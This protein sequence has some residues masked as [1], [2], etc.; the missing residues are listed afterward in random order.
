M[1]CL[2]FDISVRL[3]LYPSSSYGPEAG[4]FPPY[5]SGICKCSIPF[6][7]QLNIFNV[8]FSVWV[9][10]RVFVRVDVTY[11]LPPGFPLKTMH[12]P[13]TTCSYFP[14]DS[15]NKNHY[16]LAV[17]WLINL[18]SRIKHIFCGSFRLYIVVLPSPTYLFTAGAEGFYFHL[19]TF[20]HTPQS[21]GPLWTRDRLGAETSTWQHKHC[22]RNKH[23]CPRWDSNSRSQ[24]ALGRRPTP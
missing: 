20:K 10:V 3:W 11:I 4:N 2:K 8:F 7:L 21:V 13:H 19:I 12:F 24:Q 1:N 17:P 15:Y 9:I 5:F 14:Y 6:R 23:Q 18:S 16:L 22:T